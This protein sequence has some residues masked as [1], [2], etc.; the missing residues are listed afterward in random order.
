MRSYLY[1][2]TA[3]VLTVY[4]Q[5]LIKYRA[6]INAAP[7]PAESSRR[8]LVLMFTDPWVISAFLAAV[9]AGGAWMLAIRKEDLSVLY[10]LMA[11]TFVLVPI[12][13]ALLLG[14][15]ITALQFIGMIMIVGGVSLAALAR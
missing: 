6:L 5:V 13:A 3:L 8:F 7:K 12:F 15:R 9:V 1:V 11:L 2:S 10:P 4:A 14:E